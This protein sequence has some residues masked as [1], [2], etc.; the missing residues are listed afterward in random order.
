MEQALYIKHVPEKIYRPILDELSDD[1]Y[2]ETL[3]PLLC[4]KLRSVKGKDDYEIRGK[5]IRFGLSRGFDMDIVLQAV[6]K[7]MQSE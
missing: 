1:D 4:N 6:E 2:E 5:L 3:L 7:T